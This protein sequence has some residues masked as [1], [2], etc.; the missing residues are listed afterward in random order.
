MSSTYD[1]ITLAF[2]EWLG[3]IGYSP[4][5]VQH[6]PRRVQEFFTYLEAQQVTSLQQVEHRHIQGFY[7]LQKDRASHN[8][9]KP[10]SNSTVN[11]YLRN[12]R[13]LAQY[14]QETG[15]GFLDVDIPNEPKATPEKEILTPTE[16]MQLYNAIDEN[17]TGLGD[18][19][20]LS[21]YYGCGLRSNEGV[22]LNVSDILLEKGLLYVRKG[23]GYKERYVPFVG[24][25]YQDFK[26]YLNYCRPGLVKDNAA[27][28]AFLLNSHGRRITYQNAL[29]TLKT[30][31]QRTGNEALQNK[32]VG[33]HSLRHSIATHLLQRKMPLEDISQFLG[34]KSIYSTEVYT[35]I[36]HQHGNF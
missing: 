31:Q 4:S 6:M 20:L 21:V 15:Q 23:K 25:Q 30:L 19:A 8:S 34:H 24:S 10:L 9:G 7:Q 28:E 22:Q 3:L 2:K 27:Q 35:H 29:T 26:N 14:L 36:V 17:T 5:T 11:G 18:R 16:I 33:L 32:Q 12:L 1:R 13:L